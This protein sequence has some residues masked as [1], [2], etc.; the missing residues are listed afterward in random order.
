MADIPQKEGL[1]RLRVP[2]GLCEACEYLRLLASPRSV[3]VF[4]GRSEVDPRFPRYPPLPVVRCVGYLEKKDN[5]DFRD[6][7]DEES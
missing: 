6:L 1:E 3:F 5:K 4:C 2:A 7:K